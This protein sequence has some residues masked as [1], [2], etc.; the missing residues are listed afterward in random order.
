VLLFERQQSG[1]FKPP[2]EYPADALVTAATHDLP[3]LA[4]YWEGRDVALRREL[5]LYPTEEVRQAQELAR[6][7]DRWR[8]L[9]A[10]EREGLLPEGASADPASLP[11]MTPALML[12]LH[13]FLARSA[14][15]VLVVQPEDVLGVREQVNL[16]GT[17][18][19]HPNWRRK[20]PLPLERWPDDEG[21]SGLAGLLTAQRPSA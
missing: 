18:G 7:Q 2:A 11:E 3:T 4:A 17:I 21:F 14:A 20:L 15:R 9:R 13:A 19:E 10:L 8:L 1:E 5:A 12:A 16:P 6:M